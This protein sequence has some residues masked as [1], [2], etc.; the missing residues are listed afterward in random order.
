MDDVSLI[1]IDVL[2]ESLLVKRFAEQTCVSAGLV[3][4]Y[5]EGKARTCDLRRA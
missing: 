2:R 4:L 5:E 1:G 3:T